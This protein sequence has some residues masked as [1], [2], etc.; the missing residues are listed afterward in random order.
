MEDAESG[1]FGAGGG[2]EGTERML[3]TRL[4]LLRTKGLLVLLAL[5]LVGDLAQAQG[6][7]R[8]PD[9]WEFSFF[10][11]VGWLAGRQEF[12]TLTADNGSNLVRIDAGSGWV[13][14]VR[15]SENLSNFFAA[16]FEYAINDQPVTALNL[17]PELP[18][19]SLDQ[20]IHNFT[21]NG[22]F[23]PFGRRRGIRPFGTVGAG[24]SLFQISSDAEAAGV[25][26]G[27]DLVDRWKVAWTWGGGVK[28][29]MGGSWGLRLDFRDHVTPVPDYGIPRSA[30]LIDGVLIP[31][32]RPDGRFHSYQV[33]AGLIFFFQP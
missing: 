27:V 15:I 24:A 28:F 31:A 10:W 14:G 26:A 25:A 20:K 2:N 30:E 4:R 16:E 32:L 19:L 1:L 18:V 3:R 33:T 13:M 21:Y 7:R 5:V 11:G 8:D 29:R 23:Y 17:A 12:P 22:I 9:K 6:R